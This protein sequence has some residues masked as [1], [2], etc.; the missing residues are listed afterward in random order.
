MRHSL[1]TRQAELPLLIDRWVTEGLITADQA[2]RMRAEL[3]Q[4]ERSSLVIEALGYLGG[5]VILVAAGLLTA[6][7]WSELQTSARLAVVGGAAVALL[8][9]GLA[10]PHRLDAARTR[11]HAVLWLLSTAA[12][13]VFL[14]LFGNEVL[15]WQGDDVALLMAAG[16]AVFAGVLWWR[17]RTVL[18]QLA[19]FAALLFTAGTATAQL[20]D[21]DSLPG[22]SVW[23]VGAVWFLLGW[24]GFVVPQRAVFVLGSVGMLIGAGITLPTYAGIALGLSTVVAL[25][26]LAVRFRDL[27]LL[28]V[29]AFGAFQILPSAVVELFPGDLAPPIA[30]L[31]VGGLL[32]GAAIYT[33]HQRGEQH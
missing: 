7:Y 31:V 5:V 32:V 2:D 4:E 33:A 3:D 28:A 30:L 16:T 22:Y 19:F 10:L 8:L 20:T 21:S 15:D 12:T 11:L 29:S 26:V 13:S 6:L 14:A 1:S 23:S 9:A 17:L 24:R 18:Q 27:V 25:V